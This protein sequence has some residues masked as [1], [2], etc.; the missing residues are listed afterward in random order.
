MPRAL[1]GGAHPRKRESRNRYSRPPQRAAQLD[2]ARY[3]EVAARLEIRSTTIHATPETGARDRPC[4]GRALPVMLRWDGALRAGPYYWTPTRVES[5]GWLALRLRWGINRWTGARWAMER[6]CSSPI[7][8]PGD[9]AFGEQEKPSA[10]RK[11]GSEPNQPDQDH[12]KPPPDLR[13]FRAFAPWRPGSLALPAVRR[14]T[15]RGLSPRGRVLQELRFGLGR[16]ARTLLTQRDRQ[17]KGLGGKPALHDE[18]DF[19]F[20]GQTLGAVAV[21]EHKAGFRQVL[22]GSAPAP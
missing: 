4:V 11:V 8:I 17:G 2:L 13:I 3:A 19:D 15:V 18:V 12:Q 9:S 6:T 10:L 21:R 7:G 14:I 20:H 22:R 1:G 16:T 5:P